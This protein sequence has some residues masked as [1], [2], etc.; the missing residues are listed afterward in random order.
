MWMFFLLVLQS[1]A[2]FLFTV[3]KQTMRNLI[4]ERTQEGKAL[5]RQHDDFNEGRPILVVVR[6]WLIGNI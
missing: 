6:V 5:A 3:F 2:M 1:N 4:V